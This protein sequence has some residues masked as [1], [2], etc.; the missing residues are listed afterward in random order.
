[1]FPEALVPL[2]YCGDGQTLLV[3]GNEL[4]DGDIVLIAEPGMRGHPEEVDAGMASL[5]SRAQTLKASRWCEVKNYEIREHTSV[6]LIYFVG[7][8]ADG[9]EI[10]RYYNVKYDWYVHYKITNDLP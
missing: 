3:R 6:T 5:M 9:S 7:V 4:E 10:E 2:D 1:M 8:Y